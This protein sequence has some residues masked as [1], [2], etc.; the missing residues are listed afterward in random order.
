MPSP[1]GLT[2]VVHCR[3]EPYDVYIGRPGP[4]GNPF[5][6]GRDGNRELVIEKY[7]AYLRERLAHEPGLRE[8]IVRELGGGTVL[9]CWCAPRPCHGHVL[10]R[11]ANGG[12]P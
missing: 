9:G 6:L 5:V 10:A 12:E 4:W 7:R 3:R 1:A 11:V 2:R 8:R